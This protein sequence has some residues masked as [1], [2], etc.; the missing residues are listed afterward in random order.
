[1]IATSFAIPPEDAWLIARLSRV[2]AKR[3]AYGS[4][5]SDS[6]CSL[7][8]ALFALQRL[9]V[10]D[11]SVSMSICAGRHQLAFSCENLFSYTDDWHT[12]FRI[13][14]FANS[15]HCIHNYEMLEG[16]E[17]RQAAESRLDEFE[18]DMQDPD[19]MT[20]EDYSPAGP[21]DELLIDGHLYCAN[22]D[23]KS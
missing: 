3:L 17:K 20:I 18:A 10:V 16:E 13:Q 9:P 21:V 4:D 23:D 8:R 6:R 1:M 12:E 22:M 14:Y 2:I 11:S 15:N 19:A 5:T 7:L